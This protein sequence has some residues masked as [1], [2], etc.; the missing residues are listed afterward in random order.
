MRGIEPDVLRREVAGEFQREGLGYKKVGS[1]EA[2]ERYSHGS[3][4]A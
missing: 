3:L 1:R 4:G 2:W